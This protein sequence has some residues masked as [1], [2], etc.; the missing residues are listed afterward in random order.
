MKDIEAIFVSI[1][2]LCAEGMEFLT[3]TELADAVIK[4]A[5]KGIGLCIVQQDAADTS[6]TCHRCH[7]D[8]NFCNC[9][10]PL[11]QEHR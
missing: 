11:S 5:N 8:I 9:E 1:I 10:F 3:R 4:E 2:C 6:G 7:R